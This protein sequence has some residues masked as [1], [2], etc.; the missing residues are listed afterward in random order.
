MVIIFF[1]NH[2]H[3]AVLPQK[4]TFPGTEKKWLFLSK[5]T[6]IFRAV[7]LGRKEEIQTSESRSSW[8][9]LRLCQGAK[10]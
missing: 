9:E 2:M 7:A 5:E 4:G 8:L 3:L 6:G 1:E 10:W